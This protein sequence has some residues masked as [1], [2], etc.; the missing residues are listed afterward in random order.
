M[1]RKICTVVYSLLV[2]FNLPVLS[3]KSTVNNAEAFKIQ[4]MPTDQSISIDGELEELN[5]AGPAMVTDF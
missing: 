1:Q 2:V 4:I 3:Q 5:W